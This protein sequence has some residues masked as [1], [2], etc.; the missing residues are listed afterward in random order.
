MA[1]LTSIVRETMSDYAVEGENGYSYLTQNIEGNI[2]TIV[3]ISEYQGQTDVDTGLLVRIV[4][5]RV[6]IMRDQNDKPLV[7]ALL[8]VGIAREQIILAYAGES[9]E[10]TA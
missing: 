9:V 6:I 8:Q 7:D 10:E 2:L 3:Y 1:T 5:N 4:N